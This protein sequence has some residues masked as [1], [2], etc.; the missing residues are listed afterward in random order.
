[1][2][3]R[4]LFVSYNLLW[5]IALP[6]VLLRLGLKSIA[7]PT[8]RQ[9]LLERFGL[10][11]VLPRQCLW[12]HAVSVG[13]ALAARGLI[14]YWQQHHPQVPLLV[15]TTTPTGAEAIKRL[16]GDSLYHAYLPWD[17]EWILRPLLGRLRPRMLILMETEI[18]PSLI[19]A[20]A[21]RN[22]PV[23]LANARLSERSF[24]RYQRLQP[25][26]SSVLS[27]F[28]AVA[29][30]HISDAERFRQLGLTS[31]QLQV[32][33]SIKFDIDIPASHVAD[34]DELGA[35][36]AKRLVWIAAS[37]HSGEEEI[38]LRIHARVR[39]KIPHLLLLLVPRHPHR[40]EQIATRL[41]NQPLAFARRSMQQLPAHEES[42][43][44]I[45]TLGELMDFFQ[46]AQVAFMGNSL[47]QG[48]GH[49]PIEPAALAKPILIGPSYFNFQAII[50]AMKR[51]QAV[52]IIKDETELESRLTGLLLS[53]DLRD[54]YSQR[55]YQYFLQQQGALKRLTTCLENINSR[56][57]S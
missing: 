13:E 28:S 3:T 31:Q 22:I 43:F 27:K 44:L 26:A 54:T 2:L 29:A 48:G 35:C 34:F 32:T 20:C 21:L 49:N 12:L 19:N 4:L 52:M 38:L 6:A 1:M 50:D 40:A 23:V 11:P 46:L 7:Q 47:N 41:Q 25:L 10:W 56:C 45:D 15:T 55:A 42:V 39:D 17:L 5:L 51:D 8:Y 37:T 9:R 14:Q 36:F 16:F 18:W 57:N 24:K 30:Q 53:E 33:G